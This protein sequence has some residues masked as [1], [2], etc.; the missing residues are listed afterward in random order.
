M[1]RPSSL[2]PMCR[3]CACRAHSEEDRQGCIKV[4]LMITE[5]VH[6]KKLV[7]T[8]EVSQTRKFS[9]C[10]YNHKT[11]HTNTLLSSMS[12]RKIGEK[13]KAEDS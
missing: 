6:P 12:S 8:R 3:V 1:Q 4:R 2:L 11:L 13:R 10:S 5:S 9:N 7:R